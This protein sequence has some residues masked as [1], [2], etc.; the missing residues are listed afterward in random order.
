MHVTP[1]L[2][3]RCIFDNLKNGEI[4]IFDGK[5]SPLITIVKNNRKR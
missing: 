1:Y 2:C 5:L 4:R 3:N